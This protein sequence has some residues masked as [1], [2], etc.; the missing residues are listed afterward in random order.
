M[1]SHHHTELGRIAAANIVLTILLSLTFGTLAQPARAFEVAAASVASPQAEVRAALRES[2][3]TGGLVDLT[4]DATG[5]VEDWRVEIDVGGQIINIWNAEIIGRTG[6]RY[7]VGAVDY[8]RRLAQGDVVEFGMQVDGSNAFRL[9]S[10]STAVPSGTRVAPAAPAGAAP[11]PG[12]P[13]PPSAGPPPIGSLR[14]PGAP[15]APVAPSTAPAAA[16]GAKLLGQVSASPTPPTAPLSVAGVTVERTKGT[17]AGLPGAVFAPGPFTTRGATILDAAGNPAILNGINWFGLET[18]I[19]AP[20]GLWARNW[21]TMMDDVKSLGFTLVRIPFSGELVRTGGG[22]PSGIDPALNPD[23]VGLNGLEILDA[24]VD[25]ANR[26]GLRILLDY[27]RGPAGDG[28]NDNGLWY[29]DGGFTEADVISVWQ[30]MARRYRDKPAVIGADL[31]NEPHAGT[32][33]DGAPTDWAAAAERIG[34][35]VLAIAPNWLIVVEGISVYD[36]DPY[37]WGG[38]LQGAADRPVRLSVPNRLVYSA[39][40]Y[41]PSV[42][43]QPWFADGSNLDDKFRTNWGYLA[44]E[45]IAPVLIG[46]WGSLLQTEADRSWTR[47]IS[48]Y[49]TRNDI[50]AMWWALNPNSGDTGG[51]YQDDW[52]TL[53][54]PVLSLLDP[55]LAR[56]RPDV[57]FSSVAGRANAAV[58][59][60]VLEAPATAE[61][62]L[63]YATAD[64]TALAGVDYVATAGT[65]TFAPGQQRKS[66]TVPVL[67]LDAPAGDRFFYL[68]VGGAGTLRGSGTAVITA[69]APPAAALPFV[70]VASTVVPDPSAAAMFRIVLSEPAQRDV[71]IAF[72]I[73]AEGA[74]ADATNGTLVIPRGER[75]AVLEVGLGQ[76]NPADRFALALT[77]ASGAEIRTGRAVAT[78]PATA[79]GGGEISVAPSVDA[80]P[81]LTIDIVLEDQWSNGTLFNVVIRNVSDAPVN[82]W[83]LGINLPFAITQSWNVTLLSESN[84]RVVMQNVDWNASIAPGTSINFGFIADAANVSLDA[85]LARANVELAVR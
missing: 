60:I 29:G 77:R 1:F 52:M 42:Y 34:N 11:A 69:D 54:R 20:H 45:N 72:S 53:R 24:I 16:S 36:G 18:D 13:S 79:P 40:D 30:T 15:A 21:R 14:Q 7:T 84:G 23:L 35:A 46:E 37:W 64:G 81:Q 19:S 43:A 57:G 50:P 68:T 31:V 32:W 48:S 59:D 70:D 80:P 56:T 61:T 83:E 63:K 33:G 66:V 26:I 62:V 73:S 2:W 44:E 67:P 22:Q 74:G 17:R 5:A 27:H 76:A 38:N 49:L 55:Y 10:V 82:G 71:D 4:L 78:V 3:G 65:L 47:A 39:H 25:Y 6:T 8:N 9:L 41:P 58:F 51:L 28:P 85:L 12:L 75:E